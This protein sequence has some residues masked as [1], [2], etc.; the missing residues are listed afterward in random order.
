MKYVSGKAKELIEAREKE[1]AEAIKG[2][3]ADLQGM[4]EQMQ[5]AFETYHALRNLG[6]DYPA[7]DKYK[8]RVDYES[9]NALG[10]LLTYC[11]YEEFPIK[12]QLN[13]GYARLK[14]TENSLIIEVKPEYAYP[15]YSDIVT[16]RVNME[17][18]GKSYMFVLFVEH[19]SEFALA[20][21]EIAE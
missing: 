5:A 7:S 18:Y 6:L 1:C 16:E 12:M 2:A 11:P 17:I 10:A 21:S 20:I 13:N 15:I 8:V 4:Q 14:V 19:L 9:I 3:I